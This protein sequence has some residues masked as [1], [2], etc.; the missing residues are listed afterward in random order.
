LR[1]Q[2]GIV[3]I[4]DRMP[5][6]VLCRFDDCHIAGHFGR[7]ILFASDQQGTAREFIK[8]CGRQVRCHA[9]GSE[10]MRRSGSKVQEP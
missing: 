6:R 5:C 7:P 9:N 8:L 2:R 1:D 10:R 4:H 3:D